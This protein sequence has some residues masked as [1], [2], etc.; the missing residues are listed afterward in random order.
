M[1]IKNLRTVG[2]GPIHPAIHHAMNVVDR[3]W[4]KHTGTHARITG[5]GEEG[6]SE[7]SRH[8]GIEGDI[9]LRAFDVDADDEHLV[10]G[11]D[12]PEETRA[13]LA[14]T[15]QHAIDK[16]L[17]KRL[18]EFEYDLVWKDLGEITAHLHLE[19]DPKP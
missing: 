14:R 15:A 4:R 9:R 6:H 7:G 2:P 12:V 11:A 16:E 8:Y 1:K 19:Y 17:R 13:T 18:G 3:V 5:L 10:P